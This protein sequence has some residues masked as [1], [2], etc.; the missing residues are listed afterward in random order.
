MAQLFP[1]ISDVPSVIEVDRRLEVNNVMLRAILRVQE[2]DAYY[3]AELRRLQGYLESYQKQILTLQEQRDGD[4][5][6]ADLRSRRESLLKLR[7][8]SQKR[9]EVAKLK[10][11]REQ[12]AKLDSELLPTTDHST[13]G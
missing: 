2:D 4:A 7:T 6:V 11:M 3:H 12:L 13:P 9:S 1:K 8:L 10:K 5:A